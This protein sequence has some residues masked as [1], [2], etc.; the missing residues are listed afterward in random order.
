MRRAFATWARVV[1]RSVPFRVGTAIVVGAWLALTA[2]LTVVGN[3]VLLT[4]VTSVGHS[5]G[6]A[7]V[8]VTVFGVFATPAASLVLAQRIVAAT[9]QRIETAAVVRRD[10]STS[11]GERLVSCETT[12]RGRCRTSHCC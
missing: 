10:D 3:G 8:L 5:P 9:V 4:V 6:P 7:L 12:E 11:G 1:A 2:L